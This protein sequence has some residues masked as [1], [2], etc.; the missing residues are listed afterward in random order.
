MQSHTNLLSAV[1][2]S[3]TMFL[4]AVAIATPAFA[5]DMDVSK[6]PVNKTWED[7]YNK[8]DTAAVAALY[9][10]DAIEVTPEGIRVGP[11]AVKERIEGAINKAGMKHAVITAT[12]CNIEGAAE[13]VG[14]RL[15]E[16]LN[17]G[18][19]GW[20]LDGNRDEGW[21]H[22]EDGQSHLQH[23]AAAPT[24]QQIAKPY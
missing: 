10:A 23:H 15:E 16:R 22:L 8:G 4:G 19:C 11:A 21:E 3:A 14:R 12:K 5:A 7:A 20:L 13:M 6:C 18:A 17:T 1:T 2:L 24:D 9:T